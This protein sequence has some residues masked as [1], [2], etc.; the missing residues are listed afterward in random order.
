MFQLLIGGISSK[1]SDC[2]M[3]L[4]WIGFKLCF[5]A[6]RCALLASLS[7]YMHCTRDSCPYIIGFGKKKKSNP[8]GH[9]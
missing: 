6:H 8:S 2:D 1:T 7:G 5:T 3:A 4:G 9:R